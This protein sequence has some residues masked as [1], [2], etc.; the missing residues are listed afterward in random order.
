[1][2]NQYNDMIIDNIID[3]VE[4]MSRSSRVHYLRDYYLKETV[5]NL[6][7]DEIFAKVC[8]LKKDNIE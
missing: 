2:S 4:E 3:E 7:D 6:N 5:D 1:M 8:D